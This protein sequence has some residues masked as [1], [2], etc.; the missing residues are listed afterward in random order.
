[1]AAIFLGLATRKIANAMNDEQ[2]IRD[3]I[4]AWMRATAEGDL[5]TI[6][7]LMDEDVVFLTP[8]NPPMRGR[9]GFAESFRSIQGFRIEGE[10]DIQELRVNGDWA[11]CWTHLK[12]TMTPK[13]E[14]SPIRRSG[15]TLTIL[16]KKP[17]DRWVVFRD[18]N[19]LAPEPS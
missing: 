9:D 5:P 1:M 19:L 11:Y 13:G 2:Q 12:V 17:N 6:L 3:L 15:Y 10:S 4:A 18:A 14:G 16:R 8:G 7:P